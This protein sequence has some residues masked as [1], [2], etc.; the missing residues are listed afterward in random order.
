MVDVMAPDAGCDSCCNEAEAAEA[1]AVA[2]AVVA[3]SLPWFLLNANGFPSIWC[4]FNWPQKGRLQRK[5][6]QAT[7]SSGR[8]GGGGSFVSRGRIV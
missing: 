5:L 1:M 7:S 6:Q 4:Q 8:G 2:I 3:N